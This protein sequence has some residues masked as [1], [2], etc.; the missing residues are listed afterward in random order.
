MAKKKEQIPH[1]VQK[2]NLVYCEK[3]KRQY[4]PSLGCQLCAYEEFAKR[5]KTEEAGHKVSEELPS[6]NLADSIPVVEDDETKS[7]LLKELKDTRQRIHEL[8]KFET[9]HK[10]TAESLKHSMEKVQ[11]ILDDT[12]NVMA[13]I[14]E[15][16]EPYVVGHQQRVAILAC[17]IAAKMGLSDEQIDRLRT[18]ATLHDTG[19]IYVP[20]ETLGK[21]AELTETERA[22]VNLHA[23]MGYKVLQK[24]DF[25]RPVAQIVLQHHERFDGS[26]YPS[27]LSGEE[28]L[29]EARILAVA[30]V[31]EAM[32]SNRPHRPAPGVEKALEEISKNKGALYDPEVVDASLELFAEQGFTLE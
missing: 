4:P 28:I 23:Q 12:I 24:V 17:A 30:D 6:M 7:Q 21:P 1:S 11:R 2:G 20:T 13:S 18:A 25:P 31:I 10:Q 15:L 3:H 14:V 9:N 27:G 8:E 26:G 32:A 29:P 19:K 22:M 5:L 16:R